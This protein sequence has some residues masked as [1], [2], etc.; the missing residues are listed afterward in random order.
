MK[1]KEKKEIEESQKLKEDE[2]GEP[3][4]RNNFI[5]LKNK[6]VGEGNQP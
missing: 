5:G 1:S 3:G 2:N 6:E 4:L